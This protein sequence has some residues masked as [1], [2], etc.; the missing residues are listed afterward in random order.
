MSCQIKSASH[1]PKNMQ[2]KVLEAHL[3]LL[4]LTMMLQ[5]CLINNS[6]RTFWPIETNGSAYIPHFLELTGDAVSG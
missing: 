1:S 2:V 3:W 6:D 4:Y 5:F